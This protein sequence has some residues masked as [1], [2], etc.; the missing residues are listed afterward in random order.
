MLNMVDIH[1]QLVVGNFS[2]ANQ[3]RD[4]MEF[5]DWFL[6]HRD[7]FELESLAIEAGAENNSIRVKSEATGVNL[8]LHV[9]K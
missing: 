1:G 7:V 8:F 5:G 9:A 3:S 2:I 6:N 4:Y